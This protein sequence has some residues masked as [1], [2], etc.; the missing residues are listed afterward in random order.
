M[1]RHPATP[2]SNAPKT[3]KISSLF[4]PRISQ[5]KRQRFIAK[6]SS[7]KLYTRID[8][9]QMQRPRFPGNADV[10]ILLPNLQI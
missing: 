4:I 3:I 2:P 9:V 5:G 7:K 6:P 10:A 8:D 1:N